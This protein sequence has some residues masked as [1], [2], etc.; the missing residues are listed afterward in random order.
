[1]EKN[2]VIVMEKKKK[3]RSHEKFQEWPGKNKTL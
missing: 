2:G 1:M 3:V